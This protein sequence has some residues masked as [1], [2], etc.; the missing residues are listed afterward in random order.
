MDSV[1]WLELASGRL[2]WAD[3]MRAARVH[4]S[5]TRADLSAELPIRDLTALGAPS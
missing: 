5:G 3:A 1:T 2:D 4:A